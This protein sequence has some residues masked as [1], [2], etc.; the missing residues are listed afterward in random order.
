ML[1][2]LGTA[3]SVTA[4][5]CIASVDLAISSYANTLRRCWHDWHMTPYE[6]VCITQHNVMTLSADFRWS[7]LQS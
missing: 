3:M 1:H 5:L 6:H 4:T 7:T 2:V